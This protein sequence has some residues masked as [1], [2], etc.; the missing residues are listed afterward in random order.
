MRLSVLDTSP[1]VQGSTAR[2]ALHNT[3]DL[4]RF[5]D[6]LG[7]HRYWVPEHHG[8][9]GVAS[10]APA[11]LVA[12]IADATDRIRV[13]SGGVLLPNH[14]PLIVA[15]QFGTLEALHPGRIDLGLGR[16]PGGPP[17][18][19]AAVRGARTSAPFAELLH[20][21]LGYF[22]PAAEA[23]TAVPA[24]GN[25]PQ[26]WVL[27]SGTASAELAGATGLPYAF[28][29]HLNPGGLDAVQL[30]RDSFRPSPVAAEPQVLVSASVI[31]ADTDEHAEWLAG[32]T[33]L[34]VLSRT[35]GN[36]ILLPSPQDA[37]A[38]PYTCADREE[39][40]ARRHEVVVGSPATVR[41]ELETVL[42]T[43]GADELMVTTPVYD[44]A[45]RRRS[46]ELLSALFD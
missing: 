20:E 15:E 19:A 29:H 26:V 27:G 17:R 39:I 25:R 8:M 34:K 5:A 45:E 11:V 44:H 13:G 3:V 24:V 12:R 7:Y 32:S 21:L 14:A 6:S 2:Q 9:R 16:A 41:A 37:A 31:A 4:A 18:A 36:R 46:Y 28:A 33:R 35:R 38:H 10:C 40:A 22:E 43:T 1:I 30:Y 23:V 42:T